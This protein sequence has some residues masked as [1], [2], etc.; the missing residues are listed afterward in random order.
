[1]VIFYVEVCVTYHAG[2]GSLP[3]SDFL[4]EFYCLAAVYQEKKKRIV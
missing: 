2:R 3:L 4:K 1:M